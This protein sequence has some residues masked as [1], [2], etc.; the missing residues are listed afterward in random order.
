MQRKDNNNK[1]NCW[2]ILQKIEAFYVTLRVRY[3][4][5]IKTF[6]TILVWIVAVILALQITVYVVL[7]FPAAQTAIIGKVTRSLSKKID[8]EV[9]IGRIHL[10][11]FNRFIAENISI[12]SQSPKS[13]GVL[14]SNDTLLSCRKLSL[15]VS[16]SE[17]LK[18]KLKIN[19]IALSDGLFNLRNEDSVTTNLSRIFRIDKN[20]E[21]KKREGDGINLMAKSVRLKNFRFNLKNHVKYVERGDSTINFANLRIHDINVDINNI[22]LKNDTLTADINNISGIDSSGFALVELKGKL[23]VCAQEARIDEMLLRDNFSS[24]DARYFYMRYEDHSNLA[25][26]VNKVKLGIDL[27]RSLFDFRTIGK[28][29]PNLKNN[30]LALMLQGEVSGP[31]RN[32]KS[33]GLKASTLSDNTNLNISFHISGLPD[34]TST[35]CS[36]GIEECHTYAKDIASIISDFTGNREIDFLRKLSPGIRY[37]FKGN[38]TGLL[39][40]FVA[41]GVLKSSAGKVDVDVL[42]R[43]D[44]RMHGFVMSGIINTDNLHIGKILSNKLIGEVT[45]RSNISSLI[46]KGGKG[47][48]LSIDSLRIDRLNFNSYDYSD[49]FAMGLYENEIFD[50]RVI[51]HD[52]NLNFIFQ[53]IVP[54]KRKGEG[55]YKFYADVPYANMFALNVD[56]RDSISTLKFRVLSNIRQTEDKDI[57]GSLKI[58]NINYRNSRGVHE[59][60]N[61]E[62]LSKSADSSYLT[63]LEA[64]FM[65]MRYEATAPPSKFIKKSM[66]LSLYNNIP[67]LF[68]LEKMKR[69]SKEY[70]N[71]TENKGENYSFYLN[72]FNTSSI[73]QLIKPGLYIQDSTKLIASIDSDNIMDIKLL[74]GR[75]AMNGN[76]VRGLD[77]ALS[78]RD[79]LLNFNMLCSN[80]LAGGIGIREPGIRLSGRDNRLGINVEFTN[81]T[82]GETFGKIEGQLLF[83]EDSLIAGIERISQLGI[84]GE[85]WNFIPSSLLMT[86][87]TIVINNFGFANSD[88]KIEANG[89][90]KGGRCDTLSVALNRFNTDIFNLFTKKPFNFKGYI[91]GDA[92]V[93]TVNGVPNM[94]LNLTG[95][96]LS[97]FNEELGSMRIRSRWS[98]QFNRFNLL[99][100]TTLRGKENLISTGYYIPDE[101]SLYM[102]ASF[103]DFALHYFEPFLEGIISNTSGTLNGEVELSGPLNQLKLSSSNCNFSD[104]AFT[105]DF[106]NV[107]YLLNGSVDI[108][109]KGIFAK[110]LAIHDSF[111]G[112][113]MVTGG[114]EYNYFK[115]M[116]LNTRIDF[117]NLHSLNTDERSNDNFYGELFTTGRLSIKGPFNKI[118]MDAAINPDANS[119]L[120]IPLGSASTATKTNLLTFKPMA[121]DTIVDPYETI[122]KEKRQEKKKSQLQVIMRGNM[123]PNMNI[124]LEI[125]KEVGDII[126]ANGTGNITMNINPSKDVFTMFGDYSINMGHYRFVLPGF[127]FASKDFEI[128]PGGSINFNGA[129]ENTNIDITAAYKTKTAINTL[130]ADT[131]S[132]STRRIVECT[133]GMSGNLMNPVLKFNIN[134]PDLEPTAKVRVESALNSDDKIQKQFAALLI[135]GGFLP[136]EQSGITNNSTILHSNASE[137]LSKQ[138]NNIFQQLG[139]PLDLGLNYQP[140]TNGNDLFDVAVS[141]QLFNNRLLI[142]GN[143]GNDPYSSENNRSVI[144]NIDVDIKLDRNGRLR[145]SLF[146]HASDRYSNYLDDSQ[147]SGVGISFQQEFNNIKEIFKRK[148]KEQRDYE[149]REKEERKA[150]RKAARLAKRR[151]SVTEQQSHISQ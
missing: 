84:R 56:R 129:I 37:N 31:V 73:C 135:S 19:R 119:T 145:L 66:A 24:L 149:R 88:Q 18:L 72:L 94:I 10:V 124:Y 80:I 59:L 5:A 141:T 30:T 57:F 22:E 136:D 1:D 101:R 122:M 139:I 150:S 38:L 89:I 33:N 144:G 85:R 9:K 8:G 140:T 49:I 70:F 75:I 138:I 133:I 74:S 16:Q 121:T 71:E 48:N 95:D 123:N 3:Y 114:L 6:K 79:S 91:W 103:N 46:K 42:L 109:E 96:S 112:S 151:E 118:V 47:I 125:D 146:S 77:V 68:T 27:N 65:N 99:L 126:K 142:N 62:M 128:Q 93:A 61:I 78:N 132:V 55:I 21:K 87:S 60:G 51:C 130:I 34:V 106:T 104:F 45:M 13:G 12:V 54:L 69:Y 41:H 43:N 35:M 64:P 107:P 40:D 113:G 98:S 131:S 32:L 63:I 108:S 81:D 17:L 97:I 36:V 4:R 105:V 86:D 127:A 92:E 143:I 67:N 50:G 90:F 52:P 23:S 25:D 76:Y 116:V 20:R 117:R 29:A 115:D 102:H 15:T 110:E 82:I 58:L 28:I 2:D 7:Q 26:F 53:G 137:M 14:H 39:T 100:G 134:I 120:H 44:E 111:R 147:R 148:S 83:K 11:F